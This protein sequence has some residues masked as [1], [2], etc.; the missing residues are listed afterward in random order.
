MHS[1][2]SVQPARHR[3]VFV[4]S[5]HG[6][7]QDVVRNGCCLLCM[8]PAAIEDATK[9]MAARRPAV[10]R[11]QPGISMLPPPPPLLLSSRSAH[12]TLDP[13]GVGPYGGRHG[14]VPLDRCAQGRIDVVI[15][16]PPGNRPFDLEEGR[17]QGFV[18]LVDIDLVVGGVKPAGDD[19][20]LPDK[21]CV[22]GV[23]VVFVFVVLFVF[24]F[25]VVVVFA[26][27]V[28]FFFA[29]GSPATG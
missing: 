5:W 3:G 8:R 11:L 23:V 22:G 28:P 15:D 7:W 17:A 2:V 18:F 20:L 13:S 4:C 6:A 12:G 10:A 19:P 29:S 26:R 25:A 16:V 24:V 1:T 27:T 14:S 21:A 9:E